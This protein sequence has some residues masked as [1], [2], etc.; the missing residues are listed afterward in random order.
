MANTGLP[1]FGLP[2]YYKTEIKLR[3]Q[4]QV[5]TCQVLYSIQSLTNSPSE[6][7]HLSRQMFCPFHSKGRKKQQSNMKSKAKLEIFDHDQ[8]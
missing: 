8:G 1:S 4:P 3:Q 6:T 5:Q 7:W 2:N